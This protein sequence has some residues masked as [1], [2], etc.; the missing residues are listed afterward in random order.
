MPKAERPFISPSD[1]SESGNTSSVATHRI[2]VR[3]SASS[4]WPARW[5]ARAAVSEMAAKSPQ[6]VPK[7]RTTSEARATNNACRP[8]QPRTVSSYDETRR[9][10]AARTIIT[11]V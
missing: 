6:S 4:S 2:S 3:C 5:R 8:A 9:R 11:V 10:A 1:C 7:R